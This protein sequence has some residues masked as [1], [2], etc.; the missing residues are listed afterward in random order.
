[1]SNI[2]KIY[3]SQYAKLDS[4]VYTGGG[5]DD[6]AAL[7]AI[8]DI[9][10]DEGGVHLVMDGAALISGLDVYSNTTI[11]CMNADCGFF[12]IAQ[13]NRAIITNKEWDRKAIR[14]RNIT[15]KG[16]TYNQD[17]PNQQ[18]HVPYPMEVSAEDFGDN[19]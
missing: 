3:A 4:N 6:T 7:Q 18:H 13:S 15:L 17:A 9:A 11:E 19:H 14:T 5:T 8:L 10:R 1:M 12:Q 2:R 16:G